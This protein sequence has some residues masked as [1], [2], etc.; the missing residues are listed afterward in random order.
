MASRSIG[1]SAG[2]ALTSERWRRYI[3]SLVRNE[4]CRERSEIGERWEC[5]FSHFSLISHSHLHGGNLRADSLKMGGSSCPR[6]G[7]AGDWVKRHA[8][9][10]LSGRHGPTS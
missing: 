8:L 5:S 9:Y 1:L 3:H 6:A 10:P 2:L 4:T 7:I